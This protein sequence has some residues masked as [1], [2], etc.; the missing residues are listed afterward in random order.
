[1][2]NHASLAPAARMLGYAGLLPLIGCVAGLVLLPMHRSVLLDAGFGYAALIFSFLG[3]LWWGQGVAR[4]KASPT[5]FAVAVVPSLI[6][7]GLMLLRLLGWT[8][9]EALLALGAAILLS[10][11]VDLA[12]A[13]KRQSV[14]GWIALRLQLSTGLG[15]LTLALA[16]L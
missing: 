9:Q 8:T 3:G 4:G 16:L 2:E 15:A 14:N 10:P 1:M 5:L 6:A 11:I 12:L 13:R 7:W